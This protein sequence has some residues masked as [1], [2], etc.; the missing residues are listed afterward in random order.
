[1]KAKIIIVI[2]VKIANENKKGERM[3]CVCV[4]EVRNQKKKNGD[5]NIKSIIKL[6]KNETSNVANGNGTKGIFRFN[7]IF[8]R[9]FCFPS[10][11]EK[12]TVILLFGSI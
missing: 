10:E 1:M 4:S 12:V 6:F 11:E 5:R 7:S 9:S 8:V 3:G 2:N